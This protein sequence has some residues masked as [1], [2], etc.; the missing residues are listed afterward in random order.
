MSIG[1]K[2]H[3]IIIRLS[4]SLTAW[5]IINLYVFPITIYEYIGLEII[6]GFSQLLTIFVKRSFGLLNPRISKYLEQDKKDY[7]DGL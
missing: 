1:N 4:I 7:Q 6:I 3:S 2:I 5:W